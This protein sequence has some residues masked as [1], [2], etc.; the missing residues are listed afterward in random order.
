MSKPPDFSSPSMDEKIMHSVTEVVGKQALRILHWIAAGFVGA[1]MAVAGA[2]AWA[3]RIHLDIQQL[4]ANDAL[5]HRE[6]VERI[7]LWTAW[8]DGVDAKLRTLESGSGDRWKRSY[9]REWAA[10]LRH[11]NPMLSVPDIDAIANRQSNAP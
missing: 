10:E 4:I 9:Q 7:A 5:Q 3:T 6:T 2:S 8:R 11:G 1:A